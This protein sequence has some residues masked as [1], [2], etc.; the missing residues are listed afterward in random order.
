LEKINNVV[1]FHEKEGTMKRIAIASILTL[2]LAFTFAL[3]ASAEMTTK[4]W[5]KTVT[6]PSG[7]VIL[8][9]SGEWD[10]WFEYYGAFSGLRS[11]TLTVAIT[12]AGNTFVAVRQTE[13]PWWPKGTEAMKGE[14]NKSGFKTVYGNR[15]DVG[16]TPC[17]WEISDNGNKIVLDDGRVFT[18][19][20]TRR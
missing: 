19:T 1:F 9:M 12:Q 15:A 18:A 5:E 13:T 11:H 14:L 4:G 2:L 3:V 16:W 20:L 10:V 6:L 17:M 8:D 7:E